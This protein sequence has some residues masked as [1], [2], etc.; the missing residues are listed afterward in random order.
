MRNTPNKARRYGAQGG[1][2]SKRNASGATAVCSIAKRRTVHCRNWCMRHS[3]WMCTIPRPRLQESGTDRLL[4]LLVLRRRNGK[5]C[6]T[7]KVSGCHMGYTTTLPVSK[8]YSFCVQD[9]SNTLTLDTRSKK[10]FCSTGMVVTLLHGVGVWSRPS[11][12]RTSSNGRY[13]FWFS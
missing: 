9:S 2:R 7:Q 5:W 10:V 3:S 13:I 1:E 8:G 11:T 12:R 4:I 6:Y